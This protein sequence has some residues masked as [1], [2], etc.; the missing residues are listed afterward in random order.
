MAAATAENTASPC[1]GGS[2]PTRPL[3]STSTRTAV[4]ATRLP[5][6]GTCPICGRPTWST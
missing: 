4:P 6:T 5:V 3:P 1:V 2:M